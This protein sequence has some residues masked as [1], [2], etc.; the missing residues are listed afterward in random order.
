M[1]GN[2]IPIR[3]GELSFPFAKA[4]A[5]SFFVP[6]IPATQGSKRHVGN[7]I[8]IDS[9]KR[10]PGWR[11][12]VAYGAREAM[13]GRDPITGPVRLTVVFTLRRP[14]KH[15]RTGKHSHEL[16]PDAPVY[17]DTTPDLSKAV[18]AV[19]DAM[20][21]IVWRDDCQVAENG[22]NRKLYGAQPG[23]QITVEM[24]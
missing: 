1:S 12:A 6:G 19:E 24:L 23:A 5:I 15:F 11:S 9:N 13:D 4:P 14:K 7:G 21:G 3:S 20:K 22:I 18:R 17:C 10:L 2:A 16:R 8:M